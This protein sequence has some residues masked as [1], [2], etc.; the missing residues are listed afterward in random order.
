LQSKASYKHIFTNIL[1]D[2]GHA[3]FGP[4]LTAPDS[5]KTMKAT[6]SST[7]QI[8]VKPDPLTNVQVVVRIILLLLTNHEMKIIKSLTKYGPPNSHTKFF[9]QN[10][11]LKSMHSNEYI[12]TGGRTTQKDHQMELF[13]L[14]LFWSWHK[15]MLHI[16]FGRKKVLINGN[17]VLYFSAR[18]T[19]RRW[20]YRKS[21]FEYTFFTSGQPYNPT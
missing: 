7:H 19:G 20:E 21:Q 6:E 4:G 10:C 11:L 18:A 5:H 2:K 16:I 3:E 14:Q 1:F 13:F 17:T 15:N 9:K 8:L 12:K